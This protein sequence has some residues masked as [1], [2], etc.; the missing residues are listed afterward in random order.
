MLPGHEPHPF[1]TMWNLQS[2]APLLA[3]VALTEAT[4]KL[5]NPPLGQ[6]FVLQFI[7]DTLTRT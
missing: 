5:G 1:K 3:G 4:A 7:S 6:D 2:N